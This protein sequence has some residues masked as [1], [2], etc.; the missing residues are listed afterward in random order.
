MKNIIV[1]IC[2]LLLATPL[3][4]QIP[5]GSS[6]IGGNISLLRQKTQQG[7]EAPYTNYKTEYTI[8]IIS[9][10]PSYGYFVL[11]NLCVGANVNTL[12]A[13]STNKPYASVRDLNSDTQSIGA[14]PFV[15]YYLPLDSKLY[16]FA[17]ASY[18]WRWSQI[19]YESVDNTGITTTTIKAPY[20]M[21]D[22]GLG[23]SYFISP[24]T[25]IEGGFTFTKARYKDDDGNVTQKTN[26]MALNIG[27]RIFLRSE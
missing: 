18:S 17:A 9:I 11:N 26:N 12:F 23:L 7:Y 8:K 1:V 15:R 22:A 5:Q 21:W 19:K 27:F 25:A 4:A 24:S 3:L 13:R 10:T 6:T 14:G 2:A 20:T 16:A